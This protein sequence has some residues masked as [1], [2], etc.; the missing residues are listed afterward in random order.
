MRELLHSVDTIR[1]QLPQQSHSEVGD[2]EG[3]WGRGPGAACMM[4]FVA[5]S[6]SSSLQIDMAQ[7]VLSSDFNNL[8][9]AMKEAQK[10]YN[11]FLEADY[12][13]RM[14]G[15]AHIVAKNSKQLFD[16]VSSSVKRPLHR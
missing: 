11:T 10:H 15:A 3:G 8:I 13:K 7:K 5:V 9:Q 16:A 2:G 4:Q 6:C 1:Q 14:L 12:Q